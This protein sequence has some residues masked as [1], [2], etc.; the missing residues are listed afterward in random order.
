MIFNIVLNLVI[1]LETQALSASYT[2]TLKTGIEAFPESYK[3]KIKLLSE[4]H[5]NWEF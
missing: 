1:G 5:P 2:Q 4:L 3:E